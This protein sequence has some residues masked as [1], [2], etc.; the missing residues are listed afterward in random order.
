M[1]AYIQSV[2]VALTLAISPAYGE[3]AQLPELN[4]E[5][6]VQEAMNQIAEEIKSEI[7]G[8]V[9]KL[10]QQLIETLKLDSKAN[11]QSTDTAE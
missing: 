4:I 5:E 7:P 6:L 11:E 10:Q 1:K 2:I 9:A 8:E 3:C